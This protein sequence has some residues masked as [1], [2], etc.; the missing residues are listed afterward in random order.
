MEPAMEAR[1]DPRILRTRAHLGEALFDLAR[2]RPLDQVTVADIAERAGVNRTTFYQHYSD[3]DALLVD[4]LNRAVEG[5][6]AKIDA[7][8]GPQ[9]GRAILRAYLEHIATN[10]AFYQRILG[11]FGSAGIQA[12]L[13]ERLADALL[14][15]LD[16]HDGLV[17]LP[18]DILGAAISGA[19][20]SIIR[21]WLDQP[22][23]V[24]VDAA[25]EWIWTVLEAHGAIRDPGEVKGDA[26]GD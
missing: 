10:A 5:V 12:W 25:V 6:V 22:E 18:L 17:D 11:E 14:A 9:D 8:T 2:E 20:L 23:R 3:K 16:D 26:D 7:D 19:G 13:R 1:V 24:A 21:A 15:N 4:A